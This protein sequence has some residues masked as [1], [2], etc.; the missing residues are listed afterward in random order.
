MVVA[1]VAVAPVVAVAA[2]ALAAFQVAS[3]G[4]SNT[5]LG[6]ARPLGPIVAPF[7]APV[8]ASS[9]AAFIPVP[10]AFAPVAPCLVGVV[11]PILQ[12]QAKCGGL[13]VLHELRHGVLDVRDALL[14][15]HHD[16]HVVDDDLCVCV[17]V[18]VLEEKGSKC[19]GRAFGA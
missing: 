19:G 10:A 8:T 14:V 5:A 2:T 6:P 15:A 7:A 3:G 4:V 17:C 11:D 16:R 18:C 1:A 12:P 9:A 13:V